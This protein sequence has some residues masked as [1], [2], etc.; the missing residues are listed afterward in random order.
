MYTHVSKCK[1]D[2]RRMEKKEK[3]LTLPLWNNNILENALLKCG[4]MCRHLIN[5]Y[6]E[7]CTKFLLI[8]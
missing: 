5:V 3:K 2:K 1:N 6:C 7:I 8:L 4:L